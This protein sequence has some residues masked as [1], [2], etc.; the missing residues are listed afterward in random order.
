MSAEFCI[1]EAAERLFNIEG[2]KFAKTREGAEE[3]V[4]VLS[5]VVKAAMDA[6]LKNV[7]AVVRGSQIVIM[8]KLMSV[9]NQVEQMA[10]ATMDAGGAPAAAATVKA[11]APKKANIWFADTY[12]CDHE[13]RDRYPASDELK[14]QVDKR[15]VE[16]TPDF[17]KKLGTIVFRNFTAK[18]K[19]DLKAVRTE[20]EKNKVEGDIVQETV[21][22]KS[23]HVSDTETEAE[24]DTETKPAAKAKAKPKKTRA[25]AVAE[26]D[27][28]ADTEAETASEVEDKAES[29]EEEEPEPPKKKTAKKTTRKAKK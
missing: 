21:P 18:E 25:A 23:A 15:A 3:F 28:E 8:E 6:Q 14:D 1:K 16:G 11:A 20:M 26:A 19:K 4:G 7:G 22:K 29:E 27:T 5:D 10:A 17:F 13:F 12:S 2:Q 24:T 9:S